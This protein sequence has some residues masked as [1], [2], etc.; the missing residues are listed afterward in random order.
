MQGIHYAAHEGSQREKSGMQKEQR[1]EKR[2][3]RTGAAGTRRKEE[4][5]PGSQ[6]T[7]QEPGDMD[8]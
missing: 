7:E 6:S 1:T 4:E 8:A 2:A 5:L 3:A